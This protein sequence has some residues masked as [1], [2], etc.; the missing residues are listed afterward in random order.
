VLVIKIKVEFTVFFDYFYKGNKHSKIKI[1]GIFIKFIEFN[2]PLC[3]SFN[4]LQFQKLFTECFS[5]F[6]CFGA[7]RNCIIL[8]EPEIWL[9]CIAALA[10]SLVYIFT[11]FIL[12]KKSTFGHFKNIGFRATSIFCRELEPHKDDAAPLFWHLITKV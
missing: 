12:Q 1:F 3:R 6:Q 4:K 11:I 7:T 9:H 5:M 2:T 8:A 10:P